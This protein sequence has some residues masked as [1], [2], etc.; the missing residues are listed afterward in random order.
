MVIASACFGGLFPFYVDIDVD[1]DMDI[2]M[3]ADLLLIVHSNRLVPNKIECNIPTQSC[4]MLIFV[5]IRF[6]ERSLVYLLRWHYTKKYQNY[7]IIQKKFYN[8]KKNPS[9]FGLSPRQ[10]N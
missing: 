9:F 10:T 3:N 6:K 5:T 1:V 7:A 8:N 4:E 2:D